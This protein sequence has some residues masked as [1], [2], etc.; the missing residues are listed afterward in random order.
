M[1]FL[2]YFVVALVTVFSVLFEMNVLV[3]PPPKVQKA[4]ATA[5][6][7]VQSK[8]QQKTVV[9]ATDARASEPAS[10]APTGQ[11]APVPSSGVAS[12]K[13][14]ITVCAATY[15]SFRAS[16]CTYQ[17]DEGPRQLCDKGV[18]SDLATAA[19]VLNARADAGGAA[20]SP[21]Q[22]NV[23]ACEQAYVSFNKADCTYQPFEGPRQVCKK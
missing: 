15:Q 13:C 19:A 4:V 23:S 5:N 8:T 20:T 6:K 7:P 2:I 3:E 12:N 14:D 17:P 22:C 18:P 9:M 16:D 11:P 10:E 21:A 1:S